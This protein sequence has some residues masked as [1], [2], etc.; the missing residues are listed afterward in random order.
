MLDITHRCGVAR[1]GTWHAADLKLQVP[2]VLYFTSSRFPP[3]PFASA[4]LSSFPITDKRPVIMDRGSIFVPREGPDG[5]SI[6]PD[7][8]LPPS[9][10]ARET[11]LTEESLFKVVVGVKSI[12]KGKTEMY[13]LSGAASFLRDARGF[14]E[15]I[16]ALRTAIGAGRLLYAPGMAVPSNLA[17]LS[18]CGIDIVDSVA[19]LFEAGRGNW[20]NP[21]GVW[22]RDKIAHPPCRCRACLSEDGK[23][24]LTE[25]NEIS[26]WE[27]MQHVRNSIAAG[28]L[29]ELVERRAVNNPWNAAVLRHMDLR[30]YDFQES[31]AA[32]AGKTLKAHS[33]Q[34]LTRPEVVRFRKRIVERYSKPLSAKVLLLLPCSARKPYSYSRSHRKFREAVNASGNPSAIHEVIVTSPLGVVPREVELVYPAAHY[35]IPV[36]G[37][38]SRDEVAMVREDLES[39][40]GKNKYDKVVVH[41]D[42]ERQFVED[43]LGGASFTCKGRATSEASLTALEKELQVAVENVPKVSRIA[44]ALEDMTA[45]AKFQFGQGGEALVQGAELRGRYPMVKIL[46]GGVQQ[47]MLTERGLLSLTLDGGKVLSERNLYYVEIDDFYLQGSLFAVGVD[48][49]SLDIRAGDDVVVRH[50]NEVRAV[51]VAQMPSREMIESER[52]EAVKVRHAL[53]SKPI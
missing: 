9:L 50:G 34:S 43:L 22:V 1:T 35:D 8:A 15:R 13:V 16:V 19:V 14:V 51:G 21:D 26:L 4:L 17:V 45:L 42:A 7:H 46:R 31:H 10:E 6:P 48:F 41:L 18:Y 30:Q 38:W 20:L 29:R 32:V 47:A 52:G 33:H 25:H 53:R 37:D 12:V 2:D 49:A 24:A 40:L 44:R 3:P 27:E 11:G 28:T 36:T 5:A 23:K 39:F